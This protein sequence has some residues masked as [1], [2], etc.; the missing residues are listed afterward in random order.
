MTASTSEQDRLVV[1][2]AALAVI[3]HVLET[4]IPSPVP[5]LRPGLANVI[6]LVVL[7]RYGL[8]MAAWVSLLRVVGG[9]LLIG[10]FLAPAFLLSLVGALAVLLSLAVVRPLLRLGLSPIGSG[11]LAS[12]AHVGGQLLIVRL[13]LI[14]HDGLWL[15][16]PWL[17]IAALP[18]G[19]FT[20]MIASETLKQLETTPKGGRTASHATD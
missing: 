1:G 14:P 17:M 16:A 20:G 13:L 4:A 3:I 10:T 9:S 6:T 5:G 2:L 11:A 12:V 8:A 7:F 15:L 18:L 19:I